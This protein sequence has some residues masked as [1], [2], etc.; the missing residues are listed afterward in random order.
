MITS[1]T[2]EYAFLSNF[3][4]CQ[5][6]WDGKIYP[7][8]EHAYQAAKT[9]DPQER[10]IIRLAPTPGKARRLGRRVT[11]R[12]DWE[13]I[14]RSVMFLLVLRKFQDPALGAR[15]LATGD[16]VL[17]EGN[18]WGDTYWGQCP[19]GVGENHLGRIL[20]LVRLVL[21]SRARIP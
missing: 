8:V 11:M 1:F 10:E 4:P 6:V 16:R 7:S 2:G 18:D 13:P 14:K 15:L 3:Y 17:V 9:L 21:R 5:V 12:P 20:M 19:L